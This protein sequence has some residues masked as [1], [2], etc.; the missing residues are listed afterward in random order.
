MISE[1]LAQTS[2]W[3]GGRAVPA[4]S[5]NDIPVTHPATEEVIARV[6]QAAA[7]D[8]ETAVAIA[9]DAFRSWRQVPG[10]EKAGILHAVAA[11][12]R[13]NRAEL[14]RLVTLEMGRPLVETL[15]EVDW[16]AAIFDHYAELGRGAQGPTVSP[17]QVGQ[18]NFVVK[19]PYGVVVAIT[20]WNYPLLLLTW[21]VAPALAAG[22]SVIAKPSELSP[23]ST[24][25]FARI[26]S[27][28]LPAGVFN[29]LT[30]DGATVGAPLVQHPGTHMVTFTGSTQTGRRIG[31]A[32]AE[33][34]KK[35]HLELGGSDPLIVCDDVDLDVAVRGAVWAAF[36]NNGQVCTSAKR[37]L[38][39][40]SVYEEFVA[41]F[42][43]GAKRLR[44]GDPFGPD[45]DLG[46]MVSQNQRTALEAKIAQAAAQGARFLS[47]ARRPD[48]LR[49]G[50]FYEP[51]VAVD[52]A[53]DS[54]LMTEEIFGPLRPVVPVT[55]LAD[56][57][58][59]ANA[60]PYGLGAS[61]FTTSLERAMT[62]AEGIQSGTFWINDP[63]T[64][65]HAAPFGGT[66]SSGIGRELGIEGLEEFRES[67]HVLVNYR[68]EQKTYWFPYDWEAG[69]QKNS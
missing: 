54:I 68:A 26:T 1:R 38:V 15:D 48:H 47:G 62:A 50:W 37:L 36:L 44:L 8:I 9:N 4:T 14:A 7:A 23:L 55:D 40:E 66:K 17:G 16:C 27:H 59:L 34:I 58:A 41:K 33:R 67:K 20:P 46:P 30:G 42:A 64:D 53:R 63:L 28:L 24:L 19:Q 52:V 49:R 43:E 13:D 35:V 22:N 31:V 60:S 25:E 12:L 6:P 56:A 51:T 39:F 69:R 61:I 10:I 5:G 21:K 65:N 18:L 11:A 32:C 3:I 2:L 29:V 57:I 45:V